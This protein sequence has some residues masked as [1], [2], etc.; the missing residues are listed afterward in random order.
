MIYR[1][2]FVFVFVF[3]GVKNCLSKEFFLVHLLVTRLAGSSRLNV[4]VLILGIISS[5][6]VS[7][8][9]V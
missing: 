1:F 7:F 2:V 8:P 9:L 5:V 3:G 6:L 4:L